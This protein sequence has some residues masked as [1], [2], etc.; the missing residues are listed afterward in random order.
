M[1]KYTTDNTQQTSIKTDIESETADVASTKGSI[2]KD[3]D[4]ME[5]HH[6]FNK[7]L[8]FGESSSKLEI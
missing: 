2:G 3:S 6:R 7:D 1:I 8:F 5:T 4:S